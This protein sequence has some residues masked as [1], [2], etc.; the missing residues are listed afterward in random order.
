MVLRIVTQSISEIFNKKCYFAAFS[1]LSK[2]VLNHE[3][4]RYFSAKTQQTS[5]KRSMN[6]IHASTVE[7]RLESIDFLKEMLNSDINDG[8]KAKKIIFMV[9]GVFY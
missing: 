7:Q 4:D 9:L 3:E 8:I 2:H 6:D 5:T 1:L